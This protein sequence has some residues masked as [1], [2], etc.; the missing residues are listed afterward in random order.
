[1][2]K[3]MEKTMELRKENEELNRKLIEA[4]VALRNAEKGMEKLRGV[5]Y[6]L[7]DARAEALGLDKNLELRKIKDRL[8]NT[9]E[10]GKAPITQ[11]DLSTRTVNVLYRHGIKYI[12][13]LSKTSEKELLAIRGIGKSVINEIV[14]YCK[15]YHIPFNK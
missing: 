6:E 7:S 13:D 14:N 2:E 3:T 12:E 9:Y 5:I 4:E 11:T 1:M 15:E 8:L 10:K